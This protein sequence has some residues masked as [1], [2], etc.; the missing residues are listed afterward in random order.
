MPLSFGK[1]KA[2]PETPKSTAT[3][4]APKTFGSGAAKTEDG[5][6]KSFLLRGSAAR[7]AQQKDEA[8]AEMR[9]AEREKA[10]RYRM[11][12][13]EERV[14]TFLDGDLDEDGLLNVPMKQEHHI[15][16]GGDFK[17]FI[18]TMDDE[19]TCPLCASED[20]EAQLVAYLTV[21]DRSEYTVK[22]GKDQGKTKKDQK[23][24]F[25]AKGITYKDLCKKA[26][27]RG[28][29]KGCSFEVTRSGDKSA[30]VGSSF[31]FSKKQT[32]AE[33]KAEGL[34]AEDL[35]PLA[36]EDELTYYTAAQLLEM[37]LG[38]APSGPG[39]EKG[40]VDKAKLGAALG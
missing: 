33:L 13:G 34:S 29:L 27:K 18:C 11:K 32:M 19:G 39:Y 15:K 25:V 24:L 8:K 4:T 31:E 6:K 26:V 35:Q 5:G 7:H 12:D 38:K 1:P 30:A 23:R 17:Q 3:G 36:Y 9:K 20:K 28:G 22:Q 37:G 16:V 21:L 14:I 2:A 10:W 40:I